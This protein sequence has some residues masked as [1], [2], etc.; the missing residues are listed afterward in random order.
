MIGFALFLAVFAQLLQ[1]LFVPRLPLIPFAPFLALI[2]LQ[3]DLKKTLLLSFLAGVFIDLFS[4][5]PIGLHALNYILTS[6]FLYRIR[7]L[8]SHERPF[9]LSFFSSIVSL[10]STTFQLLLLFLFDRRVP[11][12]GKWIFADLVGAPILDGVYA[13]VWFAAPLAIGTKLHKMWVLFWLKKKN[14]SPISH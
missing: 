5:D 12:N 13:F 2:A 9:H 14:R 7:T 6:A 3:T 1:G 11:F 8:F 4:D 10:V